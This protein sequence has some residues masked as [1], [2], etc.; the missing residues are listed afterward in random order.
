MYN[1]VGY[2]TNVVSDALYTG[3]VN[4]KYWSD[5]YIEDASFF[6]MDNVN[7]GYQFNNLAKKKVDLYL[8]LTVQNAFV[9]TKYKGLDPEVFNGIDGNIYP[10]PRV[11]LLG[12][13]LD[14]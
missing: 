1:S 5:Y 3:W 2:A 12:L 7:L 4:P 13:K 9:I 6:R 14:F 10:R 11:F 8:S